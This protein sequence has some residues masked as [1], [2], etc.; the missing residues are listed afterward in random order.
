VRTLSSRRLRVAVVGL[1]K[2]GIV[3]SCVMNTL[4]NVELTALCEK[5]ALTRRLL[6]R[7][8]R[9]IRIVDSV[10]GLAGLNLDAV[11]VTT[12]I[13][14]HFAVVKDILAGEVARDLF[15]EKTLASNYKEAKRLCELAESAG[16][17]NM[18]GY[19]RRFYVTFMKARELLSQGVIG[20]VCSFKAYAYSSDFFGVEKHA[21]S[22]SRGGVLRDL[23]CHAVDLALWFFGDLQVCRVK[24]RSSAE[25]HSE[26]PVEFSVRNSSGFEGEFSASWRMENYRTSEVGFSIVGTKGSL[27]VNDDELDLTPNGGKS[28]TWHRQDLSDNVQFWLGLPEYYRED[29]HFI[30][31]VTSRSTASPDF[32]SASKVD[33][34]ISE[35]EKR[36]CESE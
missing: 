7:V 3:H 33:Q 4:P 24:P 20:E 26:D 35:V 12:P 23:G 28:S 34:I 36:G 14:T 8:Y 30:Q 18:V 15:V 6:K 2:M 27:E 25:D 5:N 17:V 11:C 19:L 10:Q 21:T 31:S 16:A 22:M 1:G 29:L 9:K 32:F 13:P